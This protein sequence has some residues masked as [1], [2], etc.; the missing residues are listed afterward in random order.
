MTKDGKWLFCPV[1]NH[2]TRIRVKQNTELI[3]FPLF[4]PMC[5]KE[6]MVNVK[7]YKVFTAE[8][9]DY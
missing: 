7:D 5:K 8:K 2:K 6:T 1:C 4:C 3:Y 9:A